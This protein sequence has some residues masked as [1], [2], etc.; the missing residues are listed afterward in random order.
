M[1]GQ[2]LHKLPAAIIDELGQY[3]QVLTYPDGAQ[4]H[5]RG[6]MK[7]GL[8]VVVKG[9]VKVGNY[10]LDGRYCLTRVLE[11]GETFG[12]FTLFAK[13]PRTHNAEA[14]G[15]SD[16]LQLSADEFSLASN[17]IPDLNHV[18]LASLATKLHESLEMMDDIRRLP[19]PV[20]LAK[21]LRT[22]SKARQSNNIV[23]RQSDLADVNGVTVLSCHKALKTLASLGLITLA[24]GRIHIMDAD[25]FSKWIED[26]SELSLI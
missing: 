1:N 15:K 13:L 2:N 26:N 9:L 12:E 17:N 19:L 8:S 6:D 10:G 20:R 16:V 21:T 3:G 14:L 22:I 18:L 7:P 4:I 5:A 25:A 23:I 11:V 24:Y